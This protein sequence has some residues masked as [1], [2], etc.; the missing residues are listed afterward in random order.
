MAKTKNTPNL[1]ASSKMKMPM[2]AA[3]PAV[4]NAI[5]KTAK[6]AVAKI[7]KKY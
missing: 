1:P 3:K 7:M 6:A 4:K 2:A 5:K